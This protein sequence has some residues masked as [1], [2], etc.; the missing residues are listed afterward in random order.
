MVAGDSSVVGR[1]PYSE[2]LR[3][4]RQASVEKRWWVDTYSALFATII[5]STNLPWAMSS[6]VSAG[7]SFG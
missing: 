3:H 6:S 4:E 7:V 2:R 5:S 1:V